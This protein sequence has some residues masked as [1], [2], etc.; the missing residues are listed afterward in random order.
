MLQGI[1]S[2]VGS[3]MHLLIRQMQEDER[4]PGICNHRKCRNAGRRED[5]VTSA[6]RIVSVLIRFILGLRWDFVRSRSPM[7]LH[8]LFGIQ[9]Q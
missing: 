7:I 5:Q 9:N 1:T 6:V 2:L 3:S 4:N 8:E